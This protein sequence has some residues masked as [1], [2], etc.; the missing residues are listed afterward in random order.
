VFLIYKFNVNRPFKIGNTI[1]IDS[2]KIKQTL[3]LG[4]V[5]MENLKNKSQNRNDFNDKKS[6]KILE[7]EKE[8]SFGLWIQVIGQIIELKGLSGIL[9]IEEDANTIG[10]H[11]I[12]TGVWI[13]T[14][15]QILEAI[16]VSSQIRE[17]DKRQL[18]KEQKIA[19]AGDLLVS[20]G[21]AFEVIG[22]LQVI[23]EEPIKIPR[24][25]P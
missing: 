25:V 19:I 7:L 2:H 5:L 12:L 24:I 16:S 4:L 18:L 1:A 9:Q 20:L 11:Q 6:K 21:S 13:R 15:G 8:V 3:V 23:E 14:I 17:T 22:G 10:E